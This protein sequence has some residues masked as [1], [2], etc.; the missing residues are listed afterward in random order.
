MN[1]KI[2]R[3]IKLAADDVGRLRRSDVYRVLEAC[4]TDNL[5]STATKQLRAARPDLIDEINA[6][7]AE[8]RA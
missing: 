3:Y 6:C 7:V 2:D 1:N 8:L 4:F 5:L